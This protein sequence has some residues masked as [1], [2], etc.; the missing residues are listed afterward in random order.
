MTVSGRYEVTD[1][2]FESTV[3]NELTVTSSDQLCNLFV[4]YAGKKFYKKL[5][6]CGSGH[7]VAW[8]MRRNVAALK[9]GHLQGIAWS[10]TVPSEL[11]AGS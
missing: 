8:P 1:L 7:T 3:E 4:I 2:N 6:S 11:V 9:D 10:V 5:R